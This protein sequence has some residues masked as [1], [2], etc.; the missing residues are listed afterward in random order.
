MIP[1]VVMNPLAQRLVQ[2][3]DRDGEDRINFR[4]FVMGLAV[5]NEKASINVKC[6]GA[7]RLSH[8]LL[9]LA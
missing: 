7:L 4:S 6:T 9:P 5:F 1:E 3:F 2:M 8:M